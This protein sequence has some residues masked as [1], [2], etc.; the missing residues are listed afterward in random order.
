MEFFRGTPDK[1]LEQLADLARPVEFPK[2]TTIF[3]EHDEAKD[4]YLIVRGEV[5]LVICTPKLACR[6]ITLARDGELIGWSPLLGRPRLSDTAHTLT[7]VEAIAFDGSRLLKLCADNP[8]LGFELMQRAAQVLAER[9][10]ATRLQL[11]DACGVRLP[12]VAIESD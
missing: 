2:N 7:R 3:Q 8:P 6:Q 5:S 11:L 4:V 10:N 1:Y 9:L 12:E